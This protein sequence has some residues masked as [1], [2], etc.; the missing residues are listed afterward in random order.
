MG[1]ATDLNP[2][3]PKQT[4]KYITDKASKAQE[5]A[6]P[7]SESVLHIDSRTDSSVSDYQ[8]REDRERPSMVRGWDD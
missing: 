4:Y 8:L 1:F 7:K 3:L 6:R 2:Q 5:G